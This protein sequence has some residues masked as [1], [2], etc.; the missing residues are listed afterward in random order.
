MAAP[1]D[2]AVDGG[3]ELD[4]R[5]ATI[6]DGTGAPLRRGD[7]RIVGDTIVEV[8]TVTPRP[9][10][11]VVDA[12]GLVLAPGVHRRAQP[13]NR[14]TRHRSRRD[15]ADVAGHHDGV[16]RAG[17]Q[18]AVPC[19]RLSRK[20]RRAS[21]TTL[22]VALLVGHATIRRQVMGD[23][24]RRAA[25]AGGGR[26]HGGARRSGDARR[27][28]RTV[29]GSRVRSR[30][31]RVDRGSRRTGARGRQTSRLLHLA[32]P[33]R[34]GHAR[35][36]RCAKRSRSARRRSCRCR[37]RTSSSARSAC[38]ARRRKSWR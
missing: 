7:V 37:S 30:Q 4:D 22:N 36:R 13:F 28:H 10:D 34:S 16:A 23:D 27:R 9:D 17:R 29:V 33:R 1:A 31:L 25:T 3:A 15:D 14:R 38:G 6:A 2:P 11:R 20:R 35:S 12:T 5:G 21:P 18:L 8:G 19:A 24:F 26:A 32:Y